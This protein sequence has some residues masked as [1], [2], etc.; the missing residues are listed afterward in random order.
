MTFAFYGSLTVISPSLNWRAHWRGGAREQKDALAYAAA[1]TAIDGICF[2]GGLWRHCSTDMRVSHCLPGLPADERCG[3][4]A[5][6][7]QRQPD[8]SPRSP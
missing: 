8:S 3:A 4:L 1:L 7:K 2:V 5:F 6:P